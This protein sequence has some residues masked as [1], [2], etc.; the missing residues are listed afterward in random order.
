MFG[1]LNRLISSLDAD[2]SSTQSHSR[3]NAYGFQVLRNKNPDLPLE[4]W[5]DFIIGINGHIIVR[6][7]G[8]LG[9]RRSLLTD[10]RTKQTRIYLL[11]KYAIAL[12]QAY[13]WTSGVLRYAT[14]FVCPYALL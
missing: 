13:R 9:G 8:C 14:L 2:T 3:D 7:V 11:Q 12:D 5:F 1:A 10:T 6:G 4:P